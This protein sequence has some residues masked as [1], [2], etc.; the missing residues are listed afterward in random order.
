MKGRIFPGDKD[1]RSFLH[2]LKKYSAVFSFRIH[3]FCLMPTHVH[4]LAESTHANLSE[5]MRRLLISYTLGFHKRHSTRGHVFAGRFRSLVVEHGDYML[6]ASRY[7]HLN[8]VEAESCDEAGEYEW[9]SMKY[10]EKPK[11][12]PQWLCTSEIL[13]WFGKKPKMYKRFVEE[14]L[15]EELKPLVWSQRFVGGR[16]FSRRIQARL[17]KSNEKMPVNP[18]EIF[19]E[20]LLKK[21][22]RKL[23]CTVEDFRE[24]RHRLRPMRDALEEMV[25]RLRSE[26]DWSYRRISEHLG[27]SAI[28]AQVLAKKGKK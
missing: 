21:Y 27:I 24:T 3:A 4:L 8:P 6:A 22:C 20:D 18:Y 5:F 9:S 10:Y 23:K 19:A 28:Y 11:T 13:G 7:I 17:D 2:Y 15:N 12:A 16:A 14:G 1:C 25:R 26:T